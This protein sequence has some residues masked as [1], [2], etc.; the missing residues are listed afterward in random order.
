MTLKTSSL[1]GLIKFFMKIKYKVELRTFKSNLFHSTNADRKKDLR[2]Q[3]FL[4]LNLNS[5]STKF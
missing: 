5:G 2:K 1:G 4:V 3:L